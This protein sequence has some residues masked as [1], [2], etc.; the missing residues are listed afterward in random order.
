MGLEFFSRPKLGDHLT[1]ISGSPEGLKK[2]LIAADC[3]K[4]CQT[5]Y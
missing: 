3:A 5:F 1:I 2:K 4:L